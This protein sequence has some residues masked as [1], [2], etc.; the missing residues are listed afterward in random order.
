MYLKT[1]SDSIKVNRLWT[2]HVVEALAKRI[3][4]DLFSL[5]QSVS[6]VS[7]S[8]A[9]DPKMLEFHGHVFVLTRHVGHVHGA[10]APLAA[11]TT[12]RGRA[13]QVVR[14][15]SWL[16]SLVS[17]TGND[18]HCWTFVAFNLDLGVGL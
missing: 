6:N 2:V 11:L 8:D 10:D 14:V 16:L 9:L 1:E 18:N 7:L 13:D 12:H 15:G 5:L 3:H 4:P 17:D